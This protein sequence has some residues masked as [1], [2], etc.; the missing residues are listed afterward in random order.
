[1]APL[2]D[3]LKAWHDFY[4]L[5]GSASATLIGLLFVAASV[6][7]GI[8]RA[9]KHFALRS[10]LSPSVVHLASI[11]A[12]CLIT[13]VPTSSW[14]LFGLLIAA[15]G[16]FGAVYS[17]MIIR[18]MLQHGMLRIVDLED[19]VWYAMLPPVGHT[20]T[21]VAG[22]LLLLG[23]PLGCAV[24]ATA[25]GALMVIGTRNAWDMTVWTVLRHGGQADALEQNEQ[26]K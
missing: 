18:N 23:Q 24:L 12:G 6:G 10:F 22:L 19:R 4:A 26:G 16:A 13:M 25:M 11:L 2:A 9:E 5:F 14:R 7:T 8:Y 3:S 15:I 20:V 1:M 17:S 21:M